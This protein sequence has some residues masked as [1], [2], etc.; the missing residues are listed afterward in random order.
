MLQTFVSLH[1]TGEDKSASMTPNDFV[2][3]FCNGMHPSVYTFV[4]DLPRFYLH[5]EN[6]SWI[7][8][9][10]LNF[11][12]SMDSDPF[13][14][15]HKRFGTSISGKWNGKEIPKIMA[16][17]ADLKN[18]RLVALSPNEMPPLAWLEVHMLTGEARNRFV[19]ESKT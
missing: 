11:Q 19:C 14:T 2:Q 1:G 9:K 3:K 4:L 10:F 6:Q 18:A 5:Y 16:A 8:A 17:L 12:R 7:P 15:L 13:L